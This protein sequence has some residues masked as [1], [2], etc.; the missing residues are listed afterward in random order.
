VL[1]DWNDGR[2]PFFTRPP[3]RDD[4]GEAAAAIVPAWGA[5]FD[6]EAVRSPSA[7][8]VQA[9]RAAITMAVKT[10]RDGAC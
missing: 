8:V 5:D 10:S 2:I 7:C 6:A 1:Q 9:R 3:K 4:H